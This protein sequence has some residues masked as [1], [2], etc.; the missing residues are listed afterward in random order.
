MRNIF[1]LFIFVLSAMGV[2]AQNPDAKEMI[3]AEMG[4]EIVEHIDFL[5]GSM[6]YP[7][8]QIQRY[9]ESQGSKIRKESV[10]EFYLARF[11]QACVDENAEVIL[12]N[13]QI[14]LMLGVEEDLS[15][16]Y[17]QAA[18][19]AESI[20]NEYLS[21]FMLTGFKRYSKNNENWFNE[22]VTALENELAE[23]RRQWKQE[24][25]RLNWDEGVKGTWVAVD[26]DKER[27]LMLN[28]IN[29]N[30]QASNSAELIYPGRRLTLKKEKGFLSTEIPYSRLG[31]AQSLQFNGPNRAISI[32]FAS[33]VI[34]DKSWLEGVA[35]AGLESTRDIRT[36]TNTII[37]TSNASFEDK[38]AASVATSLTTGLL[39]AMFTG[40][41]VS[42]R[43]EEFYSFAMAAVTP[44]VMEGEVYHNGTTI[45]SDGRVVTRDNKATRNLFVRWEEE[46]SVVF[47]SSSGRP[48]TVAPIAD[49]SPI[50][51]DYKAVKW[52]NSFFNPRTFFPAMI[53]MGVGGWMGYTG[54]KTMIPQD[55]T[56]DVSVRGAL[57]FIFGFTTMITT[58]GI[59][60]SSGIDSAD[61]TRL[62]QKSMEKLK[63]KMWAELSFAPVYNPEYNAMG[64]SMNLSF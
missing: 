16:V 39:D 6:S 41:T 52:H 55:D 21:T 23:I 7:D 2:N 47:V 27:L 51:K 32:Q 12:R 56:R 28:I 5:F 13:A 60:F 25:R 24:Q 53:G 48:I 15:E 18:K 34:K 22:E 17:V 40:M 4:D 1:L 36:E 46:D 61:R 57:M 9:L 35:Q 63:R 10:A 20:G 31:K 19:A 50:L 26:Y 3:D 43:T 44:D 58:M 45:Y 54:I 42:S 49:D 59:S 38:L 33:S 64:A 29:S 8:V 30:P 11:R 37:R 14:Y 62:N